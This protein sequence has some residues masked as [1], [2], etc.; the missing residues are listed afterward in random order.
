MSV[1]STFTITTRLL[2]HTRLRAPSMLCA[3]TALKSMVERIR[4]LV[5]NVEGRRHAGSSSTCQTHTFIKTGDKAT[6]ATTTASPT[7]IKMGSEKADG[8]QGS[9]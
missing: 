9:T 6:P 8:D 4:R 3:V 1:R 7:D 5:M 2:R